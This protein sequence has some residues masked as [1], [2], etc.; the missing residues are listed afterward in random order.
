LKI[1]VLVL[2]GEGLNCETETAHA[3]RLAGAE[4]TIVHIRDLFENSRLIRESQIL[5]LIGGFSHGD[6][7]GAG[8]VLA[9]QIGLRLKEE[10]DLFLSKDGLLIGI[11]NGFQVLTRTGILPGVQG[12]WE[13]QVTL[14]HNDCGSF[15]NRWVHLRVHQNTNCIWTQG[16]EHL[17]LPVRHGEGKFFSPG[18]ELI[19]SLENSGKVVMQYVDGLNFE[20]TM[21]YPYNP[22]GSMNSIAAITNDKGTILGMMPHPEAFLMPWHHPMYPRL[23]AQDRLKQ[24]GTPGTALFQN[25]VDRLRGS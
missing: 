9:H 10:L 23:K 7:L 25:A 22:N 21:E 14:T 24:I 8:S 6:H 2:T 16:L 15:E 20:P 5:A 4:P 19:T 13:P 11:C 12:R 18:K 1:K 3:F 17:Y